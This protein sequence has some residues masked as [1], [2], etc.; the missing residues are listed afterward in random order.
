MTG[1]SFDLDV[2]L[3]AYEAVPNFLNALDIIEHKDPV[4]LSDLTKKIPNR[5]RTCCE[6]VST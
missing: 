4:K 5:T 6:K 3:D 1:I 2:V